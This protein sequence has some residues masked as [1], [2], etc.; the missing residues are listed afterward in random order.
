LRVLR[1]FSLGT[2][3]RRDLG[4]MKERKRARERERERARELERERERERERGRKRSRKTERKNH[5]YKKSNSSL[6]AADTFRKY[7]VSTDAHLIVYV[8]FLYQLQ[9]K[10]AK[11]TKLFSFFKSTFFKG[12]FPPSQF[13]N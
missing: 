7:V 10:I 3:E 5:Y 1:N 8:Y 12:T 2:K 6:S 9:V 4:R 11:F 13:C